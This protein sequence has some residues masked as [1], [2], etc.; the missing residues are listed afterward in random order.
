[1]LIPRSSGSSPGTFLGLA[2]TPSSYVGQ[3]LKATRVNIGGTAL[4]FVSP[5]AWAVD[6]VNVVDDYGADKT[7]VADSTTPILNAINSG[8]NVYLPEGSYK[9]TSDI[10]IS[11]LR[12]S[13]YTNTPS[14]I[15]MGASRQQTFIVNYSTTAKVLY[16]QQH[17]LTIRDLCVKQ[18]PSTI[19]TAGAGIYVG[20]TDAIGA[21]DI[22]K[23]MYYVT[24]EDVDIE[25][26]YDDLRCENSMG[27]WYNR[28]RLYKPVRYGLH[29]N[30]SYP[31][32]GNWYNAMQIHHPTAGNS[33]TGVYV[34]RGDTTRMTH[35]NVV[36]F[37]KNFHFA[38]STGIITQWIIDNT[39]IENLTGTS[40][41]CVH[42]GGGAYDVSRVR[43]NNIEILP[44]YTGSPTTGI[45]IESNCY[46]TGITDAVIAW[47]YSSVIDGGIA[48][49]MSNVSVSGTQAGGYDAF[50]IASTANGTGMV[51]C[52]TKNGNASA[53]YAINIASGASN[54]RIL[55]N[56]FSGYG[57]AA[58][59]I[60]AG[61]K[62]TSKIKDNHG[63]TDYLTSV[64]ATPE[65][66]GQEA[67]VAGIWYRA[68][69]TSSSADWKALN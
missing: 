3:A 68:I 53:R 31:T 23:C 47:C 42:L 19:P 18:D 33:A 69:A 26:C 44:A 37:N 39:T 61:V 13:S 8:K 46:E 16:V 20:I 62:A 60:A 66:I 21:F 24:L 27:N 51:N 29:Y 7:G 64:S 14:Q 56:D 52:S 28:I 40:P 17:N 22:N 5:F 10:T 25:G 41:I 50:T 6:W 15:I 58:S 55:G 57:T 2:D 11:A 59:L 43:F 54:L 30:G 35:S 1:M 4:E 36:G 32:G 48:T 49:Q 12:G 65:F 38:G 34:A 45:K 67:L 9:V 63:I